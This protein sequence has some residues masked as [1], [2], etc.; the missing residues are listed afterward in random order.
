MMTGALLF[1]L[2]AQAGTLGNSC[3]ASTSQL[4]GASNLPTPLCDVVRSPERF[5]GHE[6]TLYATYRLSFEAAEL[7]CLSCFKEGRIWVSFDDSSE[8][9]KAGSQLTKVLHKK[10]GNVT[11][12]FTGVFHSEKHT[13]G[14]MGL[15]HYEVTLHS[16]RNLKV[17]DSRD[18]L[19]LAPNALDP[20]AR[21]RVC[22]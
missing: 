12:I 9:N 18:H 21:A 20:T 10:M 11:G 8:A 4:K 3:P 17:V 1:S 7:Y 16:V 19:G 13:Y 5:N 2:L 22:Q 15:Y 6:V 14:H